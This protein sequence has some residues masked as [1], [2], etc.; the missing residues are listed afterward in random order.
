MNDEWHYRDALRQLTDNLYLSIMG[1]LRRCPNEAMKTVDAYELHDQI[2]D[3]TAFN[4]LALL[5]SERL[6]E[7][8]KAAMLKRAVADMVAQAINEVEGGREL[9]RHRGY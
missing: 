1:S 3:S 7:H 5:R 8:V 4:L 9:P 2:V 6:P